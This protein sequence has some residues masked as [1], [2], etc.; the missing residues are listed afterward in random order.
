MLWVGEGAGAVG[1]VH[2]SIPDSSVVLMWR[3]VKAGLRVVVVTV[4]IVYMKI[5]CSTKKMV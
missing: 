2:T 1:A 4:M 3:A 5:I